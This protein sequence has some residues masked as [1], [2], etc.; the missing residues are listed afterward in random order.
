MAGLGAF[1]LVSTGVF[2]VWLGPVWAGLVH[3]LGLLAL[4]REGSGIDVSEEGVRFW[5]FLRPRTL[6]WA[7]IR[8]I[9]AVGRRIHVSTR[10]AVHVL[11]APRPGVLLT[12][13]DFDAKYAVLRETWQHRRAGT[14]L[15]T[16]V[17]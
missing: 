10:T 1:V 14:A 11:G 4:I 12:D 17:S 9:D 7:Q 2:L 3:V 13:E 15:R 6:I 5:G 8:D 16:G